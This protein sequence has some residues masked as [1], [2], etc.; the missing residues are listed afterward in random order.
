MCYEFESEYVKRRAEEARKAL[1][2]AA[3][4][5]KRRSEPVTPA[6][7]APEPGIKQKDP[8]PA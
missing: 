3:E 6:K 4:E 8:V 2:Q 7:P 1:Q 5:R